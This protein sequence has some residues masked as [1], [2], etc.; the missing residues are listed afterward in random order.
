[1]N[2]LG[3]IFLIHVSLSTIGALENDAPISSIICV[4]WMINANLGSVSFKLDN[5]NNNIEPN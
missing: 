1:M 3:A 2:M 4:I 5:L